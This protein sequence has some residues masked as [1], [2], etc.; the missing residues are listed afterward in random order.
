MKLY[1]IR[2]YQT[3]LYS[4]GGGLPKWNKTG[5]VWKNI[6]QLKNHFNIYKE[7]QARYQNCKES[8]IKLPQ[9]WVVEEYELNVKSIIL[10]KD[11]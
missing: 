8:E 4:L 11:L 1:R 2:N 10:A 9:E 7:I 6:G 3:N 5:K